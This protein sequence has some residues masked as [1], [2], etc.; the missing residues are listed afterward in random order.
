VAGRLIDE[1]AGL[2]PDVQVTDDMDLIAVL[3]VSLALPFLG[4]VT[5][6]CGSNPLD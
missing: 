5:E 4:V 6:E 3:D 1:E 2:A